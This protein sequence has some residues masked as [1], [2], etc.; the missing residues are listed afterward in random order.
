M[1]HLISLGSL[2]YHNEC[3]LLQL[4]STMNK[5][6]KHSKYKLWQWSVR[7]GANNDDDD[8]SMTVTTSM[9]DRESENYAF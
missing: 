3:Q 5:D 9:E 2:E 6:V 4:H 1:F 8:E 7:F